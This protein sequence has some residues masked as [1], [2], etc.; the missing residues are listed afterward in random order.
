MAESDDKTPTLRQFHDDQVSELWAD[1]KRRRALLDQSVGNLEQAGES[2][3]STMPTC[4]TPGC[5]NSRQVR[6]NG[7]NTYVC[8]NNDDEWIAC[9]HG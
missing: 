5:R 2:R 8:Q 9:S 6:I 4:D 7:R 3:G 1:Y